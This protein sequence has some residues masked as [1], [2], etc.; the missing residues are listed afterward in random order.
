MILKSHKVAVLA[1]M[2]RENEFNRQ[3][4]I[5]RVNIVNSAARKRSCADPFV[6]LNSYCAFKFNGKLSDI[7]RIYTEMQ[8]SAEAGMYL[9]EIINYIEN[10]TDIIENL[11][12]K[13]EVLIVNG[14]FNRFQR[15]PFC[16]ECYR[17]ECDGSHKSLAELNEL[18]PM[19]IDD[20]LACALEICTYHPH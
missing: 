1:E 17:G 13:I 18:M 19:D 10:G 5:E 20:C 6:L 11:E 9:R 2:R 8:I 7:W 15:D 14:L 4:K 12:S 16:T 3:L